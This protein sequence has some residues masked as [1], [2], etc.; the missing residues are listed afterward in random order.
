MRGL[1]DATGEHARLEGFSPV[2]GWSHYRL[3]MNVEHPAERRFYE[4]EAERGP[5]PVQHLERQIAHAP[6]RAPAQEP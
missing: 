5:W 4:I 2:L 1:A 6:V 3:L